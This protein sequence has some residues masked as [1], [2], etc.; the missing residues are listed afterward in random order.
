MQV[1]I[2]MEVTVVIA[3]SADSSDMAEG[4]TS[5]YTHII[6]VKTILISALLAFGYC[7]TRL[8]HKS[9]A[10][11]LCQGF[12]SAQTGFLLY[13]QLPNVKRTGGKMIQ[14]LIF[15]PFLN[16]VTQYIGNQNLKEYRHA[17]KLRWSII[18]ILCFLIVWFVNSQSCTATEMN[19]GL[20][21][22]IF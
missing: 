6:C 7:I 2:N 19:Y 11:N 4:C 17:Y 15:R 3:T 13:I 1:I 8:F 22:L 10:R 18:C 20:P 9:Q 16:I 14:K 5:C 12:F 21:G